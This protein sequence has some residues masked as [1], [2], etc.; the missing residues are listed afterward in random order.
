ML[1]VSLRAVAVKLPMSRR[2]FVTQSNQPMLRI[3]FLLL[4]I[5]SFYSSA[6][7]QT[8]GTLDIGLEVQAYPTGIIS[9]L[10]IE[11]GFAG[12]HAL[13]LRLG[14]NWIRHR[15]LGVHEDER[16]AGYGF[17]L[18]YKRYFSSDFQG[19]FLGLRSDVWWNKLD[20]KDNIDSAT[21][22][23]GETNITVI[24]PTLKAGYSFLLAN[25]WFFSPTLAFGYEVNVQTDGASV[26]EG[27][28]VLLGI[29][30]GKRF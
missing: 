13:H 1:G 11:K 14:Y 27:A 17:T 28:I 6:T 8:D 16:G 25:D 30:I 12:K 4:F 9:G 22:V 23:R 7:A 3:T 21:E 18:G 5:I 24:Q 20:W 26:G 29:G 2:L 19:W 15:D 10:R